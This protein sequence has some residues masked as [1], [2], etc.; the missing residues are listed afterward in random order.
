MTGLPTRPPEYHRTASAHFCDAPIATCQSSQV[1]GG[2]ARQDGKARRAGRSLEA[3][4]CGLLCWA[5]GL[6]SHTPSA[7]CA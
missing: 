2:V 6:G 1:R 7:C 4:S 5:L 3:P